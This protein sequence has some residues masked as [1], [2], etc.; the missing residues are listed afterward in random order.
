MKTILKESPDLQITAATCNKDGVAGHDDDLGRKLTR[1][2]ALP[3]SEIEVSDLAKN[4]KDWGRDFNAISRA[5]LSMITLGLKEK[6]RRKQEQRAEAERRAEQDFNKTLNDASMALDTHGGDGGDASED[7]KTEIRVKEV[8]REMASLF[9]A[10]QTFQAN[11]HDIG[12]M[13]PGA[14]RVIA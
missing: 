14:D 3:D 5:G 2:V 6:L 4:P 1:I 12:L 9:P 11:D 7:V 10:N 8:D 13:I